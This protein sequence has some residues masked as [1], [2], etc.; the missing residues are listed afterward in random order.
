MNFL[1]IANGI[2]DDFIYFN[3]KSEDRDDIYEVF[4]FADTYCNYMTKLEELEM[5]EECEQLNA[6][7]LIVFQSYGMTIAKS[8]VLI[9]ETINS[10]NAEDF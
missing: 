10:I 5:F 1:E 8:K 2:N 7:L 9:N 4:Y 3:N 6:A